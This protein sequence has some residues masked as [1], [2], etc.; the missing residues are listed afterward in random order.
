MGRVVN[1]FHHNRLCD[2]L[3]DHG[4]SVVIG[5]PNAHEDKNLTPTVI[6]TPS[7]DSQVMKDEIFGPIMPVYTY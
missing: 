4:G 7:R 1:D 2:L 5:N 6:L 3:K